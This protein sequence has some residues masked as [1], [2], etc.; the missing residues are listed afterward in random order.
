MIKV[1]RLV[2]ELGRLNEGLLK[3]DLPDVVVVS[4]LQRYADTLITTEAWPPLVYD[5]DEVCVQV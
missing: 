2:K 1:D 4:V 3:Q 5:A